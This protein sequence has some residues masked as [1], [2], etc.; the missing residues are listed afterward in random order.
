M[1]ATTSH[2]HAYID[3]VDSKT[4]AR[5]KRIGAGDRRVIMEMILAARAAALHQDEHAVAHLCQQ[6]ETKLHDARMWRVADWLTEG[7]AE[8]H[9]RIVAW[10][11][12][13][14]AIELEHR[15]A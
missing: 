1:S 6:I 7:A 13:S 5:R 4:Y 14:K 2:L 3:V 11:E 15:H 12:T 9:P 10:F 8:R